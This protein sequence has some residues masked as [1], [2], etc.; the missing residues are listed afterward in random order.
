M[1][2]L[3][4]LL[5]IPAIVVFISCS[6][7][8]MN[9]ENTQLKELDFGYIPLYP[10]NYWIYDHYKIDKAGNETLLDSY[11][12]IAITGTALENGK[13]YLVFEGTWANMEMKLR[14]SS[15]YYVNP[16]GNIHMSDD[17]FMDTLSFYTFRNNHTGDT[18]YQSWY[19]LLEDPG[20]VVVDAGAFETVN[21]RGTILTFNPNQGVDSIRYKNQ[22]YSRN[23]GL[24][25]DTY[26]FLGSTEK[27]ER[28]LV[29]F[30]VDKRSAVH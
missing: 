6:K 17:H 23:T 18:I 4:F 3:L 8:D 29:R 11:D 13:P 14:D 20:S 30:F 2:R 19:Q 15:G 7:N 26:Y 21:F 9:S 5:S 10:G 25:L 12:S 16:A 24:V 27:F 22:L 28:R 1:K